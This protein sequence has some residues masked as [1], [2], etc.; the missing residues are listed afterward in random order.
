MPSGAAFTPAVLALSV[1]GYEWR[2]T[3]DNRAVPGL[4]NLFVFGLCMGAAMT[5]PSPSELAGA[6]A[7]GTAAALL[8]DAAYV[9]S[10]GLRIAAL[11]SLT[12]AALSL[13][14]RAPGRQAADYSGQEAAP[15]HGV[16]APNRPMSLLFFVLCAGLFVLARPRCADRLLTVHGGPERAALATSDLV[17]TTY[18]LWCLAVFITLIV[19]HSRRIGPGA[20]RAGL[21]LIVMSAGVGVLWALWSVEDVVRVL[22]TGR[23]DIDEDAVSVVLSSA[24]LIL[25]A[26]GAT[27]TA[28]WAPA[29]GPAQWL[30]ARRTHRALRPLWSA[31]CEAAPE[32]SLARPGAPLGTRTGMGPASRPQ[33]ALYRR[34][35]EIRDGCLAM[36]PH[37]HPSVPAWVAEQTEDT[38]VRDAA[39]LAVA[40]DRA[41]ESAKGGTGPRAQDGRAT[42]AEVSLGVGGSLDDE[43]AWLLRV[44][45]A[46]ASSPVVRECRARARAD[47]EDRE[48][49][50][51][52]GENPGERR[53]DGSPCEDGGAGLHLS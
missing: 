25:G 27:T 1:A 49:R 16:T 31:L 22:L 8:P 12:T 51:G 45:R 47:G 43:A 41:A 36:R 34:V 19:H 2:L 3:R 20:V 40:L 38:A 28:W 50:E 26:L 48:D 10:R 13:G 23:Q 11:F 39:V 44:S 14:H 18:L 17:Y 33:F 24:C 9:L 15:G 6:G 37:V 29:A 53:Q 30:R 35:I 32:I 21:R 42:E 4:L 7:H 46:F 5:V 52:R